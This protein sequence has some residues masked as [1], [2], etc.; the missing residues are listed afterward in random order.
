MV[1]DTIS[2]PLVSF[3]GSGFAGFLI[4]IFLKKIF[5]IL[6]I[7]IGAFLGALFLAIQLLQAGG[8]LSQV[9]WDHI[10]ADTMA[11]LQGLVVQFSNSHIFATLGIPATGGLEV[12]L[13]AGLS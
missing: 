5:R 2:T 3:A 7:I 1:I 6:L 11:G 10:G 4:G 12:G 13:I 8:Y 9:N